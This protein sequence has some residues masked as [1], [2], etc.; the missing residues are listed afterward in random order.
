[1]TTISK[2][3]AACAAA[4]MIV[5]LPAASAFAGGEKEVE[6]GGKV[7]AY[8]KGKI[9]DDDDQYSKAKGGAKLW[10]FDLDGW[11]TKGK[12]KAWFESSSSTASSESEGGKNP[13]AA[14]ST[15]GPNSSSA[16]ASSL[17]GGGGAEAGATSASASGGLSASGSI[18]HD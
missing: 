14:A 6:I 13:S 7:W 2:F 9:E 15:D 4:A 1:M 5:S 8:A 12:F 10:E 17:G 16:S 18:G 11:G 3:A